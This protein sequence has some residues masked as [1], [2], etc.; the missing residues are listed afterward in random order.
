[1]CSFRISSFISA[2]AGTA[3]SIMAILLH[4]GVMVGW[5]HRDQVG[6]QRRLYHRSS[7]RQRSATGVGKP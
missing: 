3:G 5:Q 1:M 4:A 2:P 7:D 6:P